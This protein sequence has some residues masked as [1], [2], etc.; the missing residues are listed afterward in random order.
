MRL[1]SLARRL[2]KARENMNFSR[3]V[4]RITFNDRML[5]G[6]WISS[7]VANSMKSSQNA[8]M[9][10]DSTFNIPKAILSRAEAPE[11]LYRKPFHPLQTLKNR[12]E[13]HFR[14]NVARFKTIDDLD[15]P[16]V[17]VEDNFERLLI[18]KDHPGFMVKEDCNNAGRSPSDTY[19]VN[20]NTVLR[21]HTSAH[22]HRIL[23]K[24]SQTDASRRPDGYLVTADVYRRDEIDPTHY[25]I[26][27]QMEGIRLF[28][29][30]EISPGHLPDDIGDDFMG[31]ISSKKSLQSA[32]SV[33]EAY[34]VGMNLKRCLE[35]LVRE[36]FAHEKD[37]Q[38]RWIDAYFPFTS[39]SW[40]MEVFYRGKWL[41]LF[42]CGVMRQEILDATGLILLKINDCR[43]FR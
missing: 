37:L 12:I 27:H 35:S 18:S 15:C 5:V 42:G 29:R 1:G 41:E 22:Q 24:Y 4:I 9:P 14:E 21:T 23:Q 10:R 31:S 3:H 30:A 20:E 19:Y 43:K 28:S 6:R 34:F 16:A 38:I 32:H 17:S 13:S 2:R 26:F 40:E 36:L 33:S 39:P 25:P 8:F 11:K 7:S